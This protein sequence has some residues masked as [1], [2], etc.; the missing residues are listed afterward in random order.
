MIKKF[1]LAIA[2]QR[3]IV[4]NELKQLKNYRLVSNFANF[5]GCASKV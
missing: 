4:K 1:V 5:E 3:E 2:C